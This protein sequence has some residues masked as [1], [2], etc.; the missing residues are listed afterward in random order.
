MKQNEATAKKTVATKEEKKLSKIGKWF[1]DPNSKPL[2]KIPDM[3][4]VLR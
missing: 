2:V 3:R 1:N 4:A